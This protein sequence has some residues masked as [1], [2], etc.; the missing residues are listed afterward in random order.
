MAGLFHKE[1]RYFPIDKEE[2]IIRLEKKLAKLNQMILNSEQKIV[3]IKET[4]AEKF[5]SL[6]NECQR[7]ERT[8]RRYRIEDIVTFY[9]VTTYFKELFKDKPQE[10]ELRLQD[11]GCKKFVEGSDNNEAFLDK[12]VPFSRIIPVTFAHDENDMFKK[13]WEK[14]EKIKKITMD[15]EVFLN[16]IAIRNY[17]LALADLNDERLI[18][19]LTHFACIH[20]LYGAKLDTPL[21][22]N[23][24]RL[25]L[26]F[27]R[28][29]QLR[30]DIFREVHAIE[31]IIV[32]HNTNV[33]NNDRNSQFY[34]PMKDEDKEKIEKGEK[35]IRKDEEAKRNSF[36]NILAFVYD[37]HNKMSTF[38][39]NVRKSAAHNYYGVLFKDLAEENLLVKIMRAYKMPDKLPHELKHFDKEKDL[40][41]KDPHSFA[42]LILKKS[43]KSAVL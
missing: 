15:C 14:D 43:R 32:D 25:S 28:Y 38:T 24:N 7:T 8:I 21:R 31:K 26:E 10:A 5:I 9:M 23:Y 37:E 27:K 35:I 39:N 34:I 3:R 16:R 41:K 29:N 13:N 6:R 4:Y 18:S 22:I 12:T 42:D 19:F 33:L 36:V 40:N 2:E 20:Y 11:V 17:N 1:K 30:S